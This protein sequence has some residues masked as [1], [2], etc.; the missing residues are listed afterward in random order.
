MQS[1]VDDIQPVSQ[2]SQSVVIIMTRLGTTKSKLIWWT[3][4]HSISW[5]ENGKNVDSLSFAS[6]SIDLSCKFEMFK[7]EIE[8]IKSFLLN[9]K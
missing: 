7:S 6:I 4:P 8:A 1:D 3:I 9:C 5:N 2:V